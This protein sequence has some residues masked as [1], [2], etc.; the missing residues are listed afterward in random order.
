MLRTTSPRP[1][2]KI[3]CREVAGEAAPVRGG[4]APLLLLL[5]ELLA[6]RR[7]RLSARS[8]SSMDATDPSSSSTDAWKDDCT[9]SAVR[10]LS[11]SE[12]MNRVS[13]ASCSVSAGS[14]AD[15]AQQAGRF[16]EALILE[17]SRAA[18][19]LFQ[20]EP[21]AGGSRQDLVAGQA[22]REKTCLLI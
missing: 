2:R 21:L 14:G 1:S 3:Y 6:R 10:I 16:S 20:A 22:K 11:F 8:V 9:E 17:F 13:A 7:L 5:P 19:T 12:S 18:P 4:S 15:S